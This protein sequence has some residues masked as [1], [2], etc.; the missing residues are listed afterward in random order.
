MTHSDNAELTLT[1]RFMTGEMGQEDLLKIISDYVWSIDGVSAVLTQAAQTVPCPEGACPGLGCAHAWHL[2]G[3]GPMWQY[4]D[5][6]GYDIS[7][8]PNGD[9][10]AVERRRWDGPDGPDLVELR[11]GDRWEVA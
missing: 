4:V 9:V 8:R 3:C 6:D 5:A 11:R 1:V 10:D 2:G 7:D